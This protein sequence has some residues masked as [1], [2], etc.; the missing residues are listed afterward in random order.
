MKVAFFSHSLVSDWNHEGARFLRGVVTEL[1]ARGH[2]V[3]VFE[4]VD[5]WS[6]ENLVREQGLR[7]EHLPI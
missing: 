1:Q 2:A 6:R 4:P 3:S 7:L 5:S